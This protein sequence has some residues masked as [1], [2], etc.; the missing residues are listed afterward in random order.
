MK[1]EIYKSWDRC[2]KRGLSKNITTPTIRLSDEELEFT[3]NKNSLLISK[4]KSSIEKLRNTLTEECIYFFLTDKHG[5]LLAIENNEQIGKTTRPYKIKTGMSFAEESSGTNAISMAIHLQDP[6][7]I[8]PEEHYCE[9]FKKW[10]CYAVPL[11]L[12][13]ELVGYLD[14]STI[15]HKMKKEL[16]AIGEL[17]PYKIMQDYKKQMKASEK[18]CK[19]IAVNFTRRQSIILDHLAKGYTGQE[20]ATELCISINTVNY[21]KKIIF[22]KLGVQSSREAISKVFELDMFT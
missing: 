19:T 17:L 10:Y 14:I 11:C 21:H 7:Y 1:K 16:I 5:F 15:N 9:I 6:I 12:E 13:N 18:K 22:N 3:L 20:I 2:I 8:T 4:F